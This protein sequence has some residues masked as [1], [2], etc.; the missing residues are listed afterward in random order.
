MKTLN[1]S[2]IIVESDYQKIFAFFV[3]NKFEYTNQKSTGTQLLFYWIN[4]DQLVTC[5]SKGITWFS[6]DDYEFIWINGI[7][8]LNDRKDSDGAWLDPEYWSGIQQG[9]DGYPEKNYWDSYFIQGGNSQQFKAIKIEIFGADID[10]SKK[11]KQ[12]NEETKFED[13]EV[14]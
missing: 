1:S 5:T 8:I 4:D 14:P 10:F 6:S 9:K 13:V 2:L 7:S 12:A 3:P 11:V